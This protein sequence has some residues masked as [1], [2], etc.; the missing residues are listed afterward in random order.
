MNWFSRVAIL[1]V[2]TMLPVIFTLSLSASPSVTM[3]PAVVK[4]GDKITVTIESDGW[5]L[6]GGPIVKG[7]AE[8]SL[9]STGGTLTATGPGYVIVSTY[10]VHPNGNGGEEEMSATGTT[11]VIDLSIKTP[12]DGDKFLHGD[13]VSYKANVEP[14]GISVAEDSWKWEIIEGK[15]EVLKEEKDVFEILGFNEDTDYEVPDDLTVQVSAKIEGLYCTATCKVKELFPRNEEID[16]ATTDPILLEKEFEIFH[17]EWTW[18]RRDKS[19]SVFIRGAKLS[20]I[21]KFKLKEPLTNSTS[22]QGLYCHATGTIPNAGSFSCKSIPLSQSIKNAETSIPM[23]A[24]TN[25]PDYIY[26]YNGFARKNPTV[27]YLWSYRIQGNPYEITPK[28]DDNQHHIYI[29]L[30]KPDTG[31]CFETILYLTCLAAEKDKNEQKAVKDIWNEFSDRTVKKINKHQLTYYGLGAKTPAPSHFWST[32][33]LIKNETGRC[34]NWAG[35]LKE[36][37]ST[38]HIASN[39]VA[40]YSPNSEGFLVRN[41][42]FEKHIR[43]GPGG[44]CNTEAEGDD[45]QI[46]PKGSWGTICVTPGENGML[47]TR[48]GGNDI[49]ADGVLSPAFY[50]YLL[51]SGKWA[52]NGP[53]YGRVDGDTK[54]RQGIAGQGNPEPPEF[55]W[56]H[57]I[58]YHDGKFYDPSYGGQP[59]PSELEYENKAISGLIG[60]GNDTR[61]WL[62]MPVRKDRKG[63]QDLRFDRF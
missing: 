53:D 1:S 52:G 60:Q 24:D 54:N 22:I 35:F 4:I 38:H 51:L 43:S 58:V 27:K 16:F 37:F 19:R 33:D 18:D 5:I 55:F 25:L 36:C 31:F 21:A 13:K 59:A 45:V 49:K 42:T 32:Y 9:T 8:G 44:Y 63:V 41:W 15:G 62:N 34:G 46:T 30:A 39:L 12:S 40:I 11:T 3:E 28:P 50:P 17:P 47:E 2:A 20:L 7:P 57:G 6:K 26:A 29:T 56:D 14:S 10:W 48:Q 23:K 61:Y